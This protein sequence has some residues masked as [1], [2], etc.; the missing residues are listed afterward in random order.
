MNFYSVY[1]HLF[2]NGKR[3]VGITSQSPPEKRWGKTGNCYKGQ[4][5]IDYAISKYGWENIKHEIIDNGLD[6]LTAKQKEIYLI[7]EYKTF[8]RKFGYNVSL[9]GDIVSDETRHKL[10]SIRKGHP[11]S[12]VTRKKIGEANKVSLKG[13][14]LSEKTKQKMREANI[15]RSHKGYKPHSKESFRKQSNSLKGHIVTLETREKIRKSNTGKHCTLETRKKISD[16]QKNRTQ[17]QKKVISEKL[18]KS[19]KLSGKERSEKRKKTMS[20][21][22]PNGYKQTEDSNKAR[23]IA[24]LGKKKSEITKAKM[25][26]SKSEKQ[27][28]HMQEAQKLRREGEKLG[29]SYI[30]YKNYLEKHE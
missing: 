23:S 11:V 25:R 24:H 13:N 1:V 10:S 26:K 7:A 14:K 19:L 9:G 22:Y 2:P 3:Y 6:E 30:E 21:R 20:I 16:A 15:G 17:E 5:P 4:H 27:K 12:E 8:D 29:M 18:S 28:L